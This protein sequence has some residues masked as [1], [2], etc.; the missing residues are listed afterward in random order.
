ME[1]LLTGKCLAIN[2]R[3]PCRVQNSIVAVA[4]MFRPS[5]LRERRIRMLTDMMK[6]IRVTIL[7]I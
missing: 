7:R 1:S 5:K 6:L 4:Y 2:L 3:L